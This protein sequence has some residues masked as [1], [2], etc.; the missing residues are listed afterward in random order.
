MV[1][2]LRFTPVLGVLLLALA[3]LVCLNQ[4]TF[5]RLTRTTETFAERMEDGLAAEARGDWTGAHDAYAAAQRI[6]EAGGGLS[7]SSYYAEAALAADL[8]FLLERM[9][10]GGG[11]AV[12]PEAAARF[13]VARMF[14]AEGETTEAA[15]RLRALAEGAAAP[16]PEIWF[17]LGEA[18]WADGQQPAAVAAWQRAVQCAPNAPPRHALSPNPPFTKRLE[19]LTR[20]Y[21]QLAAANAPETRALR[22]HHLLRLGR[23]EEA[24]KLLNEEWAG[25]PAELQAWRERMVSVVR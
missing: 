5:Q 3:G 19:D 20:E 8:D 12:T 16:W 11:M 10:G 22:V 13:G 6:A 14:L 17:A 23:A 21:D 24:R 7:R 18:E 15:D 9:V 4:F 2:T 1:R 25:A